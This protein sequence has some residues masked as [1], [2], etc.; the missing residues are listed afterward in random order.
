MSIDCKTGM[1]SLCDVTNDSKVM[2]SLY[3]HRTAG[4]FGYSHLTGNSNQTMRINSR[5]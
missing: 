4:L 3:G 2:E 1:F 5:N